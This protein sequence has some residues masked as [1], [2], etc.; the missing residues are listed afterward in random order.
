MIEGSHAGKPGTSDA[1][2]R[3]SGKKKRAR[4]VSVMPARPSKSCTQRK[5]CSIST[6]CSES[7]FHA[8]E[9]K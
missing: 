6:L 2:A 7:S 9:M 1:M 8:C 5:Y 3:P 4:M